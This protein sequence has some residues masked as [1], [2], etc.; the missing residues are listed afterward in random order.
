[1]LHHYPDPGVDCRWQD[2]QRWWQALTAP[3]LRLVISCDE[4]EVFR[5]TR[6]KLPNFTRELLDHQRYPLP[7]NGQDLLPPEALWQILSTVLA[8]I[9]G[10]YW[11]VVVV[12]SNQYARW[13]V[14][15]WQAEIRS[16]ADQAAYYVHGLQQAFASDMQ[17]WQVRA[18]AGGYGKPTLVN[19]LP[20]GLTEKLHTALA[21]H[22]LSPGMIV[23]AWTLSANQAL[24]TLR[25]QK[26]AMV[27]WVVCRESGYLTIG[28]LLQGEWQQVRQI[29]VGEH[30]QQ[31][32]Q[33]HLQRELV[34][35]PERMG[36]PVCLAQASP[37]G[38][39]RATLATFKVLD[40]PPSRWL[41]EAFNQSMRRRMADASPAV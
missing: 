17:E 7:G 40:I 30:W 28:C 21:A 16:Q 15:P 10:Q 27:G 33:Q 14:L 32:L 38:A 1:M 12:L 3:E 35:H 31:T 4:L 25:Q 39:M 24:H 5:F 9:A 41:G 22:R 29:P 2:S 36:L 13:L 11:H 34:M 18:Q 20:A 37:T 8:P 26:L 23:P 19:A 6:L